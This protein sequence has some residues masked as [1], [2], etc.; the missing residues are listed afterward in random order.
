MANSITT[1]EFH[2]FLIGFFE[3]LCPWKP[4]YACPM[5]KSTI[6]ETEFHYYLAGRAGGFK[7]SK[8]FI[9]G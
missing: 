1:D 2:S 8:G 7:G 5:E 3:T 6:I 9:I 4:R